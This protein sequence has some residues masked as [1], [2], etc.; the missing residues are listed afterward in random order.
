MSGPALDIIKQNIALAICDCCLKIQLLIL[1]VHGAFLVLCGMYS[2]I[3]TC[4]S[5]S[6]KL[7]LP[8]NVLTDVLMLTHLKDT[9]LNFE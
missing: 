2:C 4:K 9:K 5:I 6:G 8:L 1:H 3:H 7:V